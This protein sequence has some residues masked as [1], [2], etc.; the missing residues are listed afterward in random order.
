MPF[1]GVFFFGLIF[2][3]PT[4]AEL[5]KKQGVFEYVCGENFT[6][7]STGNC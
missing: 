7:N 3:W 2:G 1:E 4:L 6:L 5:Y